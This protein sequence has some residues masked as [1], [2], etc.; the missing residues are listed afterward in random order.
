MQDNSG[1]L[2]G[3][4]DFKK[5]F[6]DATTAPESEGWQPVMRQPNGETTPLQ[7]KTL[8]E[9]N[10]AM[11]DAGWTRAERRRYLSMARKDGAGELSRLLEAKE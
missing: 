9:M 2:V 4:K 1:N 7:G 3:L 10:Q 11:K 6:P 5:M 8:A